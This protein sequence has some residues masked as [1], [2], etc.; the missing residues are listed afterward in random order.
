VYLEKQPGFPY[1][2][3]PMIRNTASVGT[4]P[5][6]PLPVF[7]DDVS[8]I[9]AETAAR[10]S[11]VFSRGSLSAPMEIALCFD[12]YDDDTGLSCVL[13]ALNR[14]GV[15][16]TFFMNGDFIRRHPDA[17][18]AIAESGHETASLFYAPI[19]LSDSRYRIDSDFIARGLARNEDEYYRA[20]GAELGLLWHPPFYRESAGIAQAAARAGYVTVG[21][22]IDPLDWLSREDALRLGINRVGVP[23]MIE[24]VME[25]KRPGSIIPL[26]LGTLPGGNDYLF[27]YIDVLLDA[28]LRSGYG[29]VP[30]SALVQ[31]PR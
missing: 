22:D 24:R 4:M 27:L 30:V 25:L 23:F 14:F 8:D 16:A 7:L 17:A 5:L 12:L 31:R 10:P 29:I 19:D 26:R 11:A 18:R 15:R 28:L 2:N 3:I 6:L 21:R 1:E 9:P 20:C 13:E